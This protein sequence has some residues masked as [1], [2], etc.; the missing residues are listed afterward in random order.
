ME[1]LHLALTRISKRIQ[2]LAQLRAAHRL[3][4]LATFAAPGQQRLPG[5]LT[6]TWQ[7][8][9][10]LCSMVGLMGAVGSEQE[11]NGGT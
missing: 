2:Q 4:C 7:A 8:R 10:Y 1:P 11:A 3:G 6:A 5:C 9:Q